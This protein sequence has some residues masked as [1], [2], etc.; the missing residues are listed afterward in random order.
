MVNQGKGIGF[1]GDLLGIGLTWEIIRELDSGIL[2][3]FH[4]I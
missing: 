1:N 4:G 3:M 2:G